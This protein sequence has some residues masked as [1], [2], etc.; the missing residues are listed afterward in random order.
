MLGESFVLRDRNTDSGMGGKQSK[1][2]RKNPGEQSIFFGA[3]G[4]L[5]VGK[6]DEDAGNI[7]EGLV[8]AKSGGGDTAKKKIATT[9]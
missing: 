3:K 8:K 1:K 5:G 7:C 6:D 9:R 4:R 2:T